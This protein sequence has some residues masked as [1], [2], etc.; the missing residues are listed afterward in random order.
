MLC[1]LSHLLRAIKGVSI[2]GL[3]P[4]TQ[5]P[6]LSNPTSYTNA[7]IFLNNPHHCFRGANK[8]EAHSCR[9]QL[10]IMDFANSKASLVMKHCSLWVRGQWV[11]HTDLNPGVQEFT[12]I[13]HICHITFGPLLSDRRRFT[14]VFT[15]LQRL[16][17]WE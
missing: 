1:A 9:H 7:H 4:S 14:K 11:T 10:R 16:E 17:G 12:I 5:T 8:L 15:Q 2:A 3:Q 13:T 6:L